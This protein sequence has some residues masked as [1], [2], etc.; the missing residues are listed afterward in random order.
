MAKKWL[1]PALWA[2]WRPFGLGIR[3]PHHFTEIFKTAW[4]NR[5]H[6]LYAWRI[7][8]RGVCDGCALGTTGMHDWTMPSIHLCTIRLNLLQLNTMDALAVERLTGDVAGLK[9]LSST[10]LR[11]LGRLPYPMVRKQGEPTFTRVSWDEALNLIAGRIRE[12]PPERLAFYLTSRGLTN[13][14]YY[15]AQKVARF[16]GT[17]H[18]DNAARV[19]H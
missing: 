10:E 3:K 13:E 15:V 12:S 16:L 4:E 19:C 5:S 11:T 8:T 17:N 18:V 9:R 14:V 2:D 7:L 6:P 1:A